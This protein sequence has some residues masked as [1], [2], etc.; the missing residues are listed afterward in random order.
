MIFFKSPI[1]ADESVIY[2]AKRLVETGV[3][4]EQWDEILNESAAVLGIF[5]Y[6]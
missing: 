1:E 5:D 4:K 2:Q 3:G 6:M